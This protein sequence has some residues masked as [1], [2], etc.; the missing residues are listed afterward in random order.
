M[1]LYN[2][3]IYCQNE[4][5]SL[6]VIE[7]LMKIFGFSHDIFMKKQ[8]NKHSPISE[9]EIVKLPE[10][11]LEFIS[12]EYDP[13]KSDLITPTQYVESNYHIGLNR[14]LPRN[15]TLPFDILNRT[16]VKNTN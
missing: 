11:N 13:S 6:E 5:E 12:N 4:N 9:N 7:N 2:G 15:T 1:Y 10:K 14:T 8:S 16:P 3:E